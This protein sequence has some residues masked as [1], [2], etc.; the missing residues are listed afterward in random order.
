MPPLTRAP[1]SPNSG[2]ANESYKSQINT[3]CMGGRRRDR[4]AT[5]TPSH[6]YVHGWTTPRQSGYLHAIASAQGSASQLKNCPREHISDSVRKL[7]QTSACCQYRQV[8]NNFQPFSF[9]KDFFGGGE[10]TEYTFTSELHSTNS[11]DDCSS[12]AIPLVTSVVITPIIV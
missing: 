11:T 7:Q 12:A 4:A 6:P 9:V 3:T 8:D 5:S 10:I 2:Y 1:T